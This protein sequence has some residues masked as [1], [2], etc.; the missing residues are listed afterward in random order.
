LDWIHQH[1]SLLGRDSTRNQLK[2]P[3]QPFG[4]LS[5]VIWPLRNAIRKWQIVNPNTHLRFVI[6]QIIRSQQH[7][8]A[9][10]NTMQ[11][12]AILGAGKSN[13]KL[14]TTTK[15]LVEWWQGSL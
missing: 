9:V 7:S 8:V 1:K 10:E 6:G 4:I 3:V 12:L 15:E 14:P 13:G 2:D 5:L 11:R